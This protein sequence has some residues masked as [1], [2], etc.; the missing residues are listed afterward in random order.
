MGLYNVGNIN[1][2]QWYLNMF[3]SLYSQ[4][5]VETRLLKKH[6]A[7]KLVGN[8]VKT[9]VHGMTMFWLCFGDAIYKTMLWP[10]FDHGVLV[11]D[12]VWA[13]FD[14]GMRECFD[15]KLPC[16]IQPWSNMVRSIIKTCLIM[17]KTMEWTCFYYDQSCFNNRHFDRVT[18]PFRPCSCSH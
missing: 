14:R 9:F 3:L 16:A 7:M 2:L 1:R 10:C 6:L 13:C 11:C 17:I 8:A 18:H 5:R 4:T 12:N 15:N